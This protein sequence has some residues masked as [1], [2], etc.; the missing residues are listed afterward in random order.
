MVYT[1]SKENIPDVLRLS[2]LCGVGSVEVSVKVLRGGDSSIV[3]QYVDFCK[4][5]D[6]QRT[7]HGSTTEAIR[8]TI[9]ICQE[10][11]ILVPFLASR[12]MEVVDIMELLFSQEEVMEMALWEREQRGER[13]GEQRGE[14]RGED[15]IIKLLEK[16]E[17]LGRSRE[18]LAAGNDREKLSSLAK[19]FG[20][21][22]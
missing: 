8:E 20:I 2:D 16:M 11:G 5:A 4:I 9:R 18:L 17:P 15:K 12:R 7:I 19:E 10:R 22:V 21:E 1:G 3:G 14:Q 13:R 6:E